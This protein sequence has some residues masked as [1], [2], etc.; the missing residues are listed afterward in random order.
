[1]RQNHKIIYQIVPEAI[2]AHGRD[3]KAVVVTNIKKFSQSKKKEDIERYFNTHYTIG[4]TFA[5]GMPM[6]VFR[7]ILDGIWEFTE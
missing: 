7:L 6:T 2:D 1:L 4:S 3:M 5:L